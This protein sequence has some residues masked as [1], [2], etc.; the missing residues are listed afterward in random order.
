MASSDTKA[1]P[2]DLAREIARQGD[3]R[4]TALM[5]L[6]TAADL[7]A[8]TL[9]GIFGASAVGTGAAAFA[10]FVSPHP[11]SPL[12]VAGTITAFGLFVAAVI[13]A[14]AGAPRDFYV[15]G[16]NPDVLREWSWIGHEWRS[17]VEMLDA[18]ANR[19]AQSIT[20]DGEILRKGSLRITLSLAAAV[21]SPILGL[22][23]AIAIQLR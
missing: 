4:L 23:I 5:A 15:A 14:M 10:D 11:S 16:G 17:E 3:V 18:T 7:R 13:A 9:C 1:I 19:Y 2:L 20:Q 12:I 22:I 8:T 6:A 21:V